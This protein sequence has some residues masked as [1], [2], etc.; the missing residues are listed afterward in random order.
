[1]N[2]CNSFTSVDSAAAPSC[3]GFGCVTSWRVSSCCLASGCVDGSGAVLVVL[4]CMLSLWLLVGLYSS[5]EVC[6]F[7]ILKSGQVWGLVYRF[8]DDLLVWPGRSSSRQCVSSFAVS[9]FVWH[10]SVGDFA[11]SG[12]PSAFLFSSLWVA[13]SCLGL[14]LYF[15]FVA[16]TWSVSGWCVAIGRCL[17]F[18]D[19]LGLPSV[20]LAV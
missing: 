13:C 1:M 3:F 14:P 4:R 9:A 15:M 8:C 11:R 20:A 19:P 16:W 7:G 6:F 10:S 5:R 12:I 2:R 18:H 17:G